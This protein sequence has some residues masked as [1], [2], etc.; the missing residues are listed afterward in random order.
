M[1]KNESENALLTDSQRD[2]LDGD[3]SEAK[4]RMAHQRVR[5]RLYKAITLD[6]PQLLDAL[7]DNTLDRETAVKPGTDP[8]GVGTTDFAHGLR[9][10]VSMVYLLAKA[11]KLKPERIIEDGIKQGERRYN[12]SKVEALFE[13][14]LKSPKDLTLGELELLIEEGKVDPQKRNEGLDRILDD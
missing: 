7:S 1:G 5:E 4:V 13:T 8:H 3:T 14:Y 2:H 11:A 9:D 10:T 12:Q 6:S